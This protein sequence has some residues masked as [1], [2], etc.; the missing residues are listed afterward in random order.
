[1]TKLDALEDRFT[2]LDSKFDQQATR[3]DQVQLKIDMSMDKLGKMEFEQIVVAQAV[4]AV[5]AG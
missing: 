4:Q 1:L 3:L 5:Q 2:A